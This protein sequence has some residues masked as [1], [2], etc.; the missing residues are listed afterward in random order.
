MVKRPARFWH[1]T[2][3]RLSWFKGFSTY[4][5]KTCWFLRMAVR[6][7]SFFYL[8]VEETNRYARQ[9][10]ARSAARFDK[11]TDVKKRKLKAYIGL[12]IIMGINTL[13]RIAMNW[14]SNCYIGNIG[15]R[16]TMTKNQFEEISQYMHFSDSTQEP[17]WGDDDYDRSFEVC[18]I[19][20]MV[21]SN[22]KWVYDPSKECQ[23]MKEWLHIKAAFPFDSWCQLSPLNTALKF[24]WLPMQ[25][26][27]TSQILL[28]TSAMQKITTVE[29]TVLAM[30]LSWKWQ[31]PFKIITGTFFPTIFSQIRG[32]LITFFPKT[33]M[34]MERC[35]V[36]VRTCHLVRNTNSGSEKWRSTCFY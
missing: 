30:M 3:F 16:E 34:H 23:S 31:S 8:I 33:H 28:F 6:R 24:G 22:L 20:N 19:M 18:R 35:I 12:C 29:F 36:I 15:V 5:S 2:L 14:S 9:K 26:K 13:P 4:R 1:R 17:Q 32:F 11:W 25:K 10:L 7:T 21:L 27:V